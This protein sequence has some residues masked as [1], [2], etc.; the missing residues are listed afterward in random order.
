M[1][2]L[3]QH[4]RRATTRAKLLDAAEDALLERGYAALTLADVA[5]R[6]GVT[7]GAVQRHFTT[8][9]GL[10]LAAFDRAADRQLEA[11]SRLQPTS[12]DAPLAERLHEAMTQIWNALDRQRLQLLDQFAQA[13][14]TDS[15]LYD[16]IVDHGRRSSQQVA[17]QLITQLGPE[18]QSD[19]Y[20]ET[21]L[22]L[23]SLTFRGLASGST[24]SD[25]EEVRRFIG[26]AAT[27]LARGLEHPYLH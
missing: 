20:F 16:S 25:D 9:Q 1:P 17:R 23:I 3:T 11:I 12:L 24:L 5:S 2:A 13:A 22:Q 19:P 18:R 8:K 26:H 21:A 6:A 27:L 15:E 14:Q 7:T 10:L 4:E